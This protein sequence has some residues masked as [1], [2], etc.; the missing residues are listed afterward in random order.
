MVY[1]QRNCDFMVFLKGYIVKEWTSEKS[2]QE[3]EIPNIC[4]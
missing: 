1:A 2:L 4:L 3:M